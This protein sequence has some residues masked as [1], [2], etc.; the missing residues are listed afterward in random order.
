MR[1]TPHGIRSLFFSGAMSYPGST[2]GCVSNCVLTTKNWSNP[3]KWKFLLSFLQ[4]SHLLA[5]PGYFAEIKLP[6]AVTKVRNKN[7]EWICQC[8]IYTFC[9]HPKMVQPPSSDQKRPKRTSAVSRALQ[10]APVARA[11]TARTARLEGSG[12]RQ[13]LRTKRLAGHG[14]PLFVGTQKRVIIPG[15]LRWYRISSVH[16]TLVASVATQPQWF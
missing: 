9:V 10:L 4:H 6:Q 14:K 7:P 11:R 3:K 16:S 15:F 8:K 5:Q 12:L 1:K 13:L 2:N